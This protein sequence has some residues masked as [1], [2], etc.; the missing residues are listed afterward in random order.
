MAAA[1]SSASSIAFSHPKTLNPAA[2]TPAAGSVSFS[3][4]QP[5]C[6]LA[7]SAG[8][9]GAVSAKVAS[10]SVISTT[11]PSLDFETSVFKKEKVSL[12][13]HEEF[14]VRGGRDLFPLLPEAF[15][16][17][18]QIGVLGWGSQGPA[19]AQNLRDSLAEAKLDIVVK[20]GLRKGSKSF[21]EARAAGFTEETGTLGD[22]LETVSGSDLLLL[23][24]S[25]SAQADN[26]E[27]IFSH[28][29]P[30]SILGLSHG[31]LL[32]HLQSVGLDFPKNISVIA[33][34]PKGMGPSVRRLYVQGKEINGA[35]INSSFAVHQD[36]DGRATDVA[37]G[38]S[39]ALGSPFTFATTLEQEYRSDI[40]G[41]RGIL[42][43]AVHGIVEALFRRYTEQGMNEDLAYKN[44]VE[45]ITGIVSKTI[46]KKGMLEVYNSLT[47]EGKRQFNEAYSAAYYPSMDILYECYED[48]SSG[49]E[50][51]SV[52]LAGRRFY[53]KE[54][55]PAFPM[56]NIDQTR[57]WKVG[58][59]VRSTRPQGDLGPLHPFTAG[60][61]VAM[62]MAQIEVL[63]KKGHSYSEIIN[64]SVIES[65]DSLNPFMHARGVAF[66]VDNCSTTARLGSRKWAPRFDYV[67]T[68]QAFVTV[69]K[70][71]PINQDLISNFMSD[72][73]HG[74]IEVCAQLRPTVDISVT[75]DADFVRPELRQSS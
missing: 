53:E 40:F 29:K 16:G 5:P 67:L 31:F 69:D 4:A 73:V 74:A 12:A 46:S 49:S 15:K 20:I 22:I 2:K 8:S 60:V 41:E 38:W 48:V 34:C 35:G 56:G 72:P 43:G 25:D 39:I 10:P 23:L 36:V 71:S 57:M 54:G 37:L 55:L 52:V 75:A 30:N 50:I 19:Q 28:M 51:R 14:I 63:R 59:R 26:Y 13:G 61:F 7:T 70:K 42:L 18:K 27:K 47:E 33:V 17:I 68:Q 44:T 45:C 11:M 24:I 66:M 64:E 9:R 21:Q 58:E 32:G 62:M 1:T 3:A 65:V 6:L